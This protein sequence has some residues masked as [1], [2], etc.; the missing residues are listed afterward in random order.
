MYSNI[1]TYT[2]INMSSDNHRRPRASPALQLRW[3]L[4]AG[5]DLEEAV[6]RGDCGL[7]SDG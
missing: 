2:H 5:L 7:A 3:D 4:A 1:Y 6:T